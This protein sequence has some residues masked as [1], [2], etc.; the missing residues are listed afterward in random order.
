MIEGDFFSV[1]EFLNYFKFE[2]VVGEVIVFVDGDVNGRNE[3]GEGVVN[4][5]VGYWVFVCVVVVFCVY[6]V[7]E[8][9]FDK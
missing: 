9:L 4:F 3:F 2:G 1:V 7:S 5:V 6:R 8:V